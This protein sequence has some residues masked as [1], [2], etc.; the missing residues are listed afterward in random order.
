MGKARFAELLSLRLGKPS[1]A[2]PLRPSAESRGGERPSVPQGRIRAPVWASSVILFLFPSLSFNWSPY[3][4]RP[5][6]TQ[7]SSYKAVVLCGF[8]CWWEP[9]PSL[10]KSSLELPKTQGSFPSLHP[11]VGRTSPIQYD[12]SL[13]HPASWLLSPW[14]LGCWKEGELRNPAD[15]TPHHVFAIWRK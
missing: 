6:S 15:S 2:L 5:L 8:R 4:E 1:P 14:R 11:R 10:L 12:I 7:L 13:L 3:L 9:V